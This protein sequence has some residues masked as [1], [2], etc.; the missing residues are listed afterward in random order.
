MASQRISFEVKGRPRHGAN[1]RGEESCFP[2]D[3]ALWK[4]EET[5]HWKLCYGDDAGHG[6]ES[7]HFCL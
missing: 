4:A 6:G 3:A 7:D 1:Q 2:D 5:K